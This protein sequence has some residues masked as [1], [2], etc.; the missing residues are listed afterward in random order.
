MKKCLFTILTALFLGSVLNAG[1]I[2]LCSN[3]TTDYRIVFDEST[4]IPSEKEAVR[5]LKTY[6][7][8]LSGIDFQMAMDYK[9][10]K[11]VVGVNKFSEKF[12]GRKTLESLGEEEILLKSSK[13]GDI[14]L[15]GGR[16]RG[17]LY[18]VYYFLDNILGVHW[19]SPEFEY[20]PERKSIDLKPVNI[21]ESPA[22]NLRQRSSSFATYRK[23]RNIVSPA[24]AARNK[25]NNNGSILG[26]E[27]SKILPEYGY[28]EYF[29]PPYPCHALHLLIPPQ[30]YFKEHP[31]WW[32]LQNGKRQVF[33]STRGVNASYCLSS[34]E[35]V[36]ETAKQVSSYL[37]K[38]PECKY[39]SVAEGDNTTKPCQCKHCQALL[40]KFGGKESG[41]WINFV[42][43]V[44]DLISN[45][46]PKTKLVTLAYIKTASPPQNIKAGDNVAVHLCIWGKYRGTPYNN[47]LNKEGRQFIQ[48][49]FLPWMKICKNV[50]IWDYI[51][52]FD[53]LYLPQPDILVNIDNM[54]FFK[55]N[56]VSVVK[57]EGG[58]ADYGGNGQPFKT[59]LLARC[60]WN[61]D[62]IDGDKLLQTYCDEYFGK[63][64][65]KYIYQYYSLLRE[66]NRKANYYK[67][68]QAGWQGQAPHAS[69]STMLKAD[70]LF[71]QALAAAANNG[72]QAYIKHLRIAY[73]SVQY[74]FMNYYNEYKDMAKKKGRQMP[75]NFKSFYDQLLKTAEDFNL[76]S[77]KNKTLSSIVRSRKSLGDIDFSA[78]ASNCY[79]GTTPYYVFDRN[80]ASRI[81]FGGFKGWL[82][83]EFP[84]A[85][86]IERISI[87]WPGKRNML[88]K[89]KIEGSMDGKKYFILVPET[90]IQ[91]KETDSSFNKK[92]MASDHKLK[93]PVL[94]K[95][96]K[97]SVTRTCYTGMKPNWTGISEELFNVSDMDLK[98]FIKDK[99]LI[100][101]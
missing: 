44:A 93:N 66:A 22:F 63:A 40:K 17:T 32:A 21:N 15:V 64:S 30:K 71:R 4:A 56:K 94:V 50:L 72:S 41:L 95:F 60:Q 96:I 59:W 26:K 36:K 90:L 23:A 86:K 39:I 18:A 35:L 79:G 14:Y 45:K 52:T 19:Y 1:N 58:T 84:Q 11:I 7:K 100:F 92:Q 78:T 2:R 33:G 57:A 74:M 75:D 3:G 34:K 70:K 42:N 29:A 99:A 98:N 65:G 24:W 67:I 83:V 73:A 62:G 25:L 37:G 82:K 5:E 13:E 20:V 9:A 68:N 31:D 61:P 91:R 101:K 28:G 47:P 87:V 8:K 69:F 27:F 10:K 46:Y 77:S 51:V 55:N 81:A 76:Y 80:D 54:Q 43:Q 49:I 16:P 38:H 12:F 89:Y 48:D 6:L 97:T 53:N 88:F 85:R